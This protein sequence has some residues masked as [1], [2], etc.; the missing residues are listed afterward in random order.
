MQENTMKHGEDNI[1][2]IT[3]KKWM[4]SLDYKSN[5]SVL[6]SMIIVMYQYIDVYLTWCIYYLYLLQLM[7]KY[8]MTK[9]GYKISQM[10]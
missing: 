10:Y 5:W 6:Y 4:T 9:H 3:G 1:W 7:G 2:Y 8:W